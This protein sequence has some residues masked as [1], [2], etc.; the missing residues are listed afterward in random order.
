M[1]ANLTTCLVNKIALQ[2]VHHLMT[3]TGYMKHF[4]SVW[5]INQE[6]RAQRVFIAPTVRST[7]ELIDFV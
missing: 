3:N 7:T 6:P 4:F 5:D 1:V 2:K